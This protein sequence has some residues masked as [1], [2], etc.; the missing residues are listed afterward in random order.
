MSAG[1]WRTL[2]QVESS[3]RVRARVLCSEGIRRP[4]CPEAR[5]AE[6]Q[7]ALA[8]EA[9]GKQRAASSA[10]S[11]APAPPPPGVRSD[12]PSLKARP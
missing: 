2:Q 6:H 11:G 8:E 3:C 5:L 10:L 7:E 4:W 1:R 9:Q 12:F